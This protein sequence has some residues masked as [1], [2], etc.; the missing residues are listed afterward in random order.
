MKQ[1]LL[2]ARDNALINL[3]DKCRHLDSTR[4]IT[5]VINDEKYTDN[6]LSVWDT[7]YRHFDIISL[8]EYLGWYVPWQ[9][10]PA[11]CEMES[12]FTKINRL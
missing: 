5:S 8:N 3:T 1:A 4:L 12:G 7:L 10:R 11:G 6:T 2:A 9:G